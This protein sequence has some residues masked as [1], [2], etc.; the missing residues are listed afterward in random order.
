MNSPGSKPPTCRQDEVLRVI[1]EGGAMDVRGVAARMGMSY[2]GIKRH[3]LELER[4]GL[5]ASRNRHRGAGRPL[6]EYSLTRRGERW[7][8]EDDSA[9]AIPL[10][11]HA[12]ALFGPAAPGK[13]LY[14]WSRDLGASY[15]RAMPGDGGTAE[16]MV[17]LA[18]LRSAEGRM[19]SVVDGV[20]IVER[21]NPLA[22]LHREF[23]EAAGLEEGAFRAALGVPV[24]RREEGDR[25][26]WSVVFEL[27]TPLGARPGDR[28]RAI[29]PV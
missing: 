18:A 15:A 27:H 13:L 24:R 23:P 2:T 9:V 29:S 19:A 20:A 11:R 3:C 21:H 22:A 17:A 25:G 12:A 8:R 1:K 5:L 16:K 10:L 7:F 4:R 28:P 14:L 26:Q 6:L